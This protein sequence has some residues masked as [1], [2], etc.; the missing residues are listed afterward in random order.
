MCTY[1]VYDISEYLIS[2]IMV[3]LTIVVRPSIF[4][5]VSIVDWIQGGILSPI[6]DDLAML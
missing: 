2:G 1:Q 3:H 4:L 6:I 5:D